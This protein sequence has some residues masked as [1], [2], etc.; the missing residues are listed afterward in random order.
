M[1]IG[2]ALSGA[3][4]FLALLA[5]ICGG[6]SAQAPEQF[7]R[8]HQINMLVGF[9]P[10]GGYDAYTRVLARHVARHIPGHPQVIVENMPGAAS[11]KSVQ[12][13]DNGAARDGSVIA[14]FN[15]GLLTQSFISADKIQFDFTNVAWIGSISRDL[16][17]CYAWG[18]TGIRTFD[19]LKKRNQFNMGAAAQGTASFIDAAFLRKMF[20]V[21]VHFVTGYQGSGEVRMAIERG[22]LDG[23]CGTWSSLPP[24]WTGNGKINPLVRF[25]S[26][27]VPGVPADV[28]FVGDM[29]DS[30]DDRALLDLLTAPDVLGRPYVVSKQVPSDRLAT[31]RSAFDATMQDG[32]FLAETARMELPVIGSTS[33]LTAQSI[34]EST[35]RAPP[36]LIARAREV[37]E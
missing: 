30:Q 25:S 37:I 33:G 7:Y 18:Q 17:A 5:S 8:D 1:T 3:M 27:P 35:Y 26:I 12:Y 6:A 32:E 13:L 16:R 9:G 28:P 10:G 20:G 29:M 4:A 2:P 21:A 22:E 14:A 34:V 24:D 19:D 31:L 11:L 15:S 36:A 23:D